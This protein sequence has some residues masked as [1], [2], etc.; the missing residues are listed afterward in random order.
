MAPPSDKDL[1][2]ASRSLREGVDAQRQAMQEAR[3]KGVFDP[4]E[5]LRHSPIGQAMSQGFP[6]QHVRP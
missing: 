5:H 1:I 3:Q 6:F 2:N 4:A